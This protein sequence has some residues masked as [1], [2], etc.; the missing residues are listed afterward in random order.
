MGSDSRYLVYRVYDKKERP[1][2][3]ER[4][5]L[6]GWSKN[7]NVA[8]AFLRQRSSNKYSVIK[9]PQEKLAEI[10]SENYEDSEFMI[11][12][13]KLK[14]AETHEEFI[15][16]MT[17]TEML[18]AEIK[19]QRMFHNLSSLNNIPG[20]GNYLELFLNLKDYYAEAL[21]YIGYR[22][23]EVD[24]LFPSANF[25]DDISDVSNVIDQI[26]LAYNGGSCFPTETE[27][28]GVSAPL[29]LSTIDDVANKILYSLESFI[30]VLKDDM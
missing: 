10:F 11:D 27:T 16:F 28:Y 29:G 13:I 4:S 5:R 20:D 8:K 17:R 21:R 3:Y 15:V 1:D 25:H 7:K 14:S 18:E 23:S 19:I 2:I 24:I 30:K 9:M 22:P 6:Y 12:F 26:E